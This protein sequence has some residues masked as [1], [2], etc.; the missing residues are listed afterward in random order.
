MPREGDVKVYIGGLP[1]DATSEE[2]GTPYNSFRQ[3]ISN[4]ILSKIFSILL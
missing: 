1:P 4:M 2:V 3:K